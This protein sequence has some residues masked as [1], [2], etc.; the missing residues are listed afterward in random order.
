MQKWF[1]S[2][3]SRLT[4]T[5]VIAVLII[6]VGGCLSFYY[7]KQL[8][9]ATEVFVKTTLPSIETADSLEQ[10]VTE[11]GN[12]S[13]NLIGSDTVDDL[14]LTYGR[15]EVLLHK[16]ED[17]TVRISHE[18]GGFDLLKLNWLSQAIRTLVLQ[19]FQLEAHKLE[20]QLERKRILGEIRLQ[21][22]TEALPY[23]VEGRA[24]AANGSLGIDSQRINAELLQSCLLKMVSLSSQLEL[25]KT[26]EEIDSL[27]DYF[28]IFKQLYRSRVAA[29]PQLAAVESA[30]ETY[31]YDMESLYDRQRKYLLIR[32]DI[33]K[34]SLDLDEQVRNLNALASESVDVVFSHFHQ[35]AATVIKRERIGIYI[36]AVLTFGAI[37]LLYVLYRKIV[38]SGFGNRLSLISSAMVA[39]SGEEPTHIPVQGRDEIAVM[40]KAAE[41]LLAKA[42]RLRN[43]AAVDQ[44]TQVWNRRQ[45]FELAAIETSRSMRRLST[46]VIMMLDIDHF[47]K[48]NDEYGHNFGDY[49]LCEVAQSCKR[50]I[51]SIDIFARYGGEEFALLMPETSLNEGVIAAE[52]IRTSI[53]AQPLKTRT[54][55]EVALTVSIG[56]TEARLNEVGIDEAIGLADRALYCA[57]KKGRNRVEIF[58]T[59]EASADEADE[60]S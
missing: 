48:V 33:G 44:L 22:L 26:P 32:D 53:A 37:L 5:L 30:Y 20:I 3:Q 10:T 21:L 34:F 51:R 31:I 39:E 14:S 42:D 1:Y 60:I 38:V 2:I 25:V 18:E 45:F 19:I 35:T 55:N 43:L 52:R 17:T 58:R 40:A 4:A 13:R 56:V 7:S 8:L 12:L 11:I 50:S 23:A 59:E 47:K 46:S 15:L 9:S 54:G 57:K 36:T 28:G 24:E 6:L 49:A 27:E 41:D 29:A 16:L